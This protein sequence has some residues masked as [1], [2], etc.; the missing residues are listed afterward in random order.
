[1]QRAQVDVRGRVLGIQFQNSLISRDRLTLGMRIFFERDALREKSGNI[2]GNRSRF[3]CRDS[4]AGHY[5][6]SIRKIEHELPSN[7]L[8]QPAFVAKSN[9]MPSA[10]CARFK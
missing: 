5:F 4:I 10:E 2:C 6:L 1:M 9:P 8:K 3:D 7:R